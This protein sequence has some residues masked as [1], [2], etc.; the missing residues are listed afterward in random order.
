MKPVIVVTRHPDDGDDIQTFGMEKEPTIVYLDLG[1]SFDVTHLSSHWDD[2]DKAE[3]IAWAYYQK[4]EADACGNDEAKACAYRVIESVLA[5]L[6]DD[7][8]VL[9]RYDP[10]TG[11]LS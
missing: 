6:G 3:V 1:A 2:D 8:S 4:G 11:Y 7:W 9:D 5:K 10:D